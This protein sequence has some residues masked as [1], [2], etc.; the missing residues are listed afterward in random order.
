MLSPPRAF[1][2]GPRT[3]VGFL[4]VVAVGAFLVRA[5][6]Q[7]GLIGLVM[8]AAW[9]GLGLGARRLVRQVSKLVPLSLVIVLGYA[10]FAEDPATDRWVTLDLRWFD[11]R[12]NQSGA[13]TGLAMALRILAVVTA[14]H[15]AR[16]GDTRALAHGLRGLGMPKLAA[17]A[18][19]ATLALL[20]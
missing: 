15:V 18:I 14:S 6:W 5:W 3:R 10:L 2:G 13:L 1:P 12:L 16:T 19:D 7:V 4:L 20:D 17:I 9:L 11:L 8:M